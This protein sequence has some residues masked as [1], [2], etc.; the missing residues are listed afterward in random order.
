M[1]M[2]SLDLNLSSI[3]ACLLKKLEL[4]KGSNIIKEQ[5]E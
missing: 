2:M 4:S 3:F 1:E 5:R